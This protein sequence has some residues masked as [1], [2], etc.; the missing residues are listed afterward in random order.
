[1]KFQDFN[2]NDSLATLLNKTTRALATR[3]QATFTREGFDVTSEQWMILLL[4][5]EED[6]RFPYQLADLIGKDRAAITRLTDGLEKRNLVIRIRHSKDQRHKQI[7][8]TPKGKKLKE[9]LVPLGI[10]NI[11]QAQRGL[12][13]EELETCKSVLKKLYRNLI[14]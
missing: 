5:W 10:A 1:M 11:Q 7:Y 4:L 8:L 14:Q 12:N 9:Q 13:S 2:P 6:G 3:L